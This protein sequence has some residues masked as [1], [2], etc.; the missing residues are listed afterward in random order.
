M[1]GYEHSSAGS[2][3]TYDTNEDSGYD[4]FDTAFSAW[5]YMEDQSNIA[6]K[7]QQSP[8]ALRSIA[9]PLSFELLVGNVKLSIVGEQ[10]LLADPSSRLNVIVH[11]RLLE[12]VRYVKESTLFD[13]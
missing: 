2:L 4:A 9:T 6:N 11:I 5:G 1:S 7:Y 10:Q 13:G 8:I 12:H 3:Y